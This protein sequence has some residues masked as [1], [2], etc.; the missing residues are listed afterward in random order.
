[1]T[2]PDCAEPAHDGAPRCA[3]CGTLLG[4]RQNEDAP[5]PDRGYE[6]DSLIVAAVCV[7]ATAALIVVL[8]LA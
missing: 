8:L 3:G 2:C 5:E 1:M 7:L 6:G 4:E